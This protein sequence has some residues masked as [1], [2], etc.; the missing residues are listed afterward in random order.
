MAIDQNIKSGVLGGTMFSAF[1]NIGMHDIIFTALM[2]VIG[3]VVSF[4]V[5]HF[6][7][8]IFQNKF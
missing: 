1:F 3:A 6:L 8:K 5:S 4:I 2:A 7:K